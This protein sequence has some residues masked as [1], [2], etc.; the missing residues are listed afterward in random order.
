MAE[1]GC[2]VDVSHHIFVTAFLATLFH[3]KCKVIHLQCCFCG[4]IYIPISGESVLHVGKKTKP[5]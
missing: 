1:E 2:G 3:C 4:P 5:L